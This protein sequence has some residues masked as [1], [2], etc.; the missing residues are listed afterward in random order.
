MP[1]TLLKKSGSLYK[2][3]FLGWHAKYD[4]EV[5]IENELHRLAKLES[6]SNFQHWRL[7]FIQPKDE[8]SFSHNIIHPIPDPKSA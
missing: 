2:F 1:A 6:R 7:S 8:V 3:H 5:C 4:E